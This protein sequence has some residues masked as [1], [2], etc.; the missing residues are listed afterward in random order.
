M[1]DD[2][3]IR[4]SAARVVDLLHGREVS[5]LELVEASIR[6]IE[7]TDGA[8]NA[9]PVRCFDRAREQALAMGRGPLPLLGGLPIVVKDNN[10]VGGVITSGGTALFKDRLAAVSDRT[11]AHM[12]RHGAI[13]MAK[14]N[15]SEL[16]GANTTNRL[17]GATRNPRDKRLTCGGS[18]GGS[19]VAVATGQVWLAHGN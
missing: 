3:L 6:R 8:L 19:A 2:A 10:D 5:P 12:E 4:M 17:F 15:L 13:P 18:S 16:G 14:A 9:L 1:S 11:I 7:A